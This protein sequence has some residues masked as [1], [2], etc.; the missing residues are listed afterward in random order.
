M[1]VMCVYVCES[2]VWC[3]YICILSIYFSRLSKL[4][5]KIRINTSANYEIYDLIFKYL[6]CS[7]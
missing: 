1:C 6:V 4:F 3:I 2:D 7:Q 5:I